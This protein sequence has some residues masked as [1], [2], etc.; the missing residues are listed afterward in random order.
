MS[1]SFRKSQ[2]TR[3][4]HLG[5]EDRPLLSIGL[6]TS[7][8]TPIGPA[9]LTNGQPTNSSFTV[10]TSGRVT[11]IAV[12]PGIGTFGP[13]SLPHFGPQSFARVGRT[14]RCREQ[15]RE[16]CPGARVGRTQR[17]RR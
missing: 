8:W 1:R 15:G 11:G 6:S 16:G 10:P 5:L 12:A 2:G 7:N 13:G 9:P 3:Q 17:G 14:H 4:E